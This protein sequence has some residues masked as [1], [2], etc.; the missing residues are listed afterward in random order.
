[1]DWLDCTGNQLEGIDMIDW[2]SAPEGTT[3][4]GSGFGQWQKSWYVISGP[5]IATMLDDGEDDEW[6]CRLIDDEDREELIPGLV[7]RP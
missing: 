3:H 2:E 7:K 5:F 1:M 6:E 4:Y